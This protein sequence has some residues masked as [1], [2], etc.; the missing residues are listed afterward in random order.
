MKRF[1]TSLTAF[2]SGLHAAYNPTDAQAYATVSAPD[3]ALPDPVT[4]RL[5][6]YPGDNLFAAHRSHSSHSSHRSHRSSSGGGSSY[7]SPSP[8]YSSPS[9]SSSSSSSSPSKLYGS[10]G[11]SN[12]TDPGRPAQVSPTPSQTRSQQSLTDA[13]KKKL[14][15]MRIQ[16]ELTMLGHYSDN[17]DGILGPKTRLAIKRFQLEKGLEINGRMTTDTLNALGVPAVR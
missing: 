5:L 11:S 17:V 4:L 1:V 10:S 16:L 2:V 7:R 12:P 8:S 9:S 3:Q 15:I 14:Q 6:N 13:E